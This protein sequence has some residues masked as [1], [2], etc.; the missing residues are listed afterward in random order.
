[1]RAKLDQ[2]LQNDRLRSEHSPIFFD[3]HFLKLNDHTNSIHNIKFQFSSF[4]KKFENLIYWPPLL[5]WQQL[6]EL[7]ICHCLQIGRGAPCRVLLCCL[8]GG[9]CLSCFLKKGW[10]GLL[11]ITTVCCFTL[12]H[13]L[14][15]SV[16]SCKHGGFAMSRHLSLPGPCH[17]TLFFY[18]RLG[19]L[20]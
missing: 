5:T 16:G 15:W 20:H 18:G 2:R 13:H 12:H 11:F 7:C 3:S 1:M 10:G 17:C 6:A 19:W 8:Q 14:P 9:P 4:F